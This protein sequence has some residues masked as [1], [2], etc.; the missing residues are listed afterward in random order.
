VQAGL[1]VATGRRQPDY[2]LF[3]SEDERRAADLRPAEARF[4]DAVA[5]ADAKRFARPL[6]RRRVRGSLSEDPVAQIINYVAITHRRWG[7]LT[8]GGVWRLYGAERN[9]LAGAHFEVDLVAALERGD[10]VALR[11]FLALF[12]AAAFRPDAD[13]RSFLDRAL[14][15]STQNARRVGAELERQVFGA[16]PRIAEGLLAEDERSPASLGV[17]FEHALILL[18]RLLFCLHAEARR[19][20]PVDNPHYREYSLQRQRLRITEEIGRGRVYS[21]R[22]DDLYNELRA[23]F[24]IV[25]KGDDALG[26]AEYDGGLFSPARHPWFEGRSVP[27]ELMAPA[28]DA[29]YRVGGELVDYGDL[30]VRHLGAI[31][32]RLLD[33]AL[34]DEDG[35]L[36][37]AAAPGRRESGSYFTPEP[38]VDR[39]VERVLEPILSERSRSAVAAGLRGR[40]ALDFLLDVRVL[41]PAMGSGH[42]LVA[43]AGWIAQHIA[44]DP[45]YDGELALDEI[46]RLVAERCIYGVDVNPMAVELAGLSLW[47]ATAR[48]GEPLTFLANL[49]VGNALVGARID[50]LLDAGDT[51]FGDRLARDTGE[52]LEQIEEI[53]RRGSA[54]GKDVHAKERLA[55]TAAALRDPLEKHADAHVRGNLAGEVGRLFHW[56]LEFP[57]VFLSVDGRP[58]DDAGFDAIVGN[59][60]YVRIQA[61][62]RDLAAYC[63]RRYASASGSFDAYVPFV[64]RALELLAPR[65][66]LGFIVPNKLL[67]VEYGQ[68]LRARLAAD[69]LVEEIVDFGDAQLFAGATNY[70]CILVLSKDAPEA[71]RYRRVRGGRAAVANALVDLDSVPAEP[72][73]SSELG[74]GPWVLATGGEARLLR[75][76]RRDAEPLAAVTSGIF[77]GLQT[78]ADAVYIVH[79]RGPLGAV[80]RVLS[81]ASGRELELE[82]DLLHPLASGVDVDRYACRPLQDLLLFPYV[83]DGGR[84]RLLTREELDRLPLTLR[85]LQEHER[86]LRSRERGTMDHAGWYGYVYPKSLGAHDRPKLGV[87]ATVRRLEVAAD[88][89]GSVY[90]HNVRVNG[91][92]LEDGG[93]SIW[94]LL[95][96]LNSMVLD[97]AFRRG[98]AVHA[99]GYYAA[100]K[101]FIAHL[102][103]RVPMPEEA[104]R[105]DELGRRLYHAARAIGRERHGFL[106]WLGD[107]LGRPVR[108]LPGRTALLAYEGRTSA[109]V[110]AVLARA[111]GDVAARARARGFRDELAR[112]HARSGRRL[113]ELRAAMEADELAAEVAVEELYELTAAQRQLVRSEY[114]ATGPGSGR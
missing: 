58:R 26:V 27:D 77:T 82:P 38:I 4:A 14:A 101:Q 113:H 8:N 50:E 1:A 107:V 45:A 30:S 99:N 29:L 86:T 83:R 32:E 31:Y 85:Y 74:A 23:L 48:R 9:L 67:K 63:R 71:L 91:I 62:S 100:N 2:A 65:G 78:N 34:E 96:L 70:T 44:T 19:L 11:L 39:I 61:L 88:P 52:L 105:L 93:P 54:T 13:G 111:R 5:V 64:E 40:D 104:A 102:P 6:D 42:F 57:E 10:D 16:V 17:A 15:E 60:P 92:L 22:S 110:L 51:I 59:P 90:F 87:A 114:Q 81:R 20:L 66:R 80:R 84:M 98:A 43:A 49:R 112:E 46:Q 53:A 89:D 7:V 35:R 103:I 68:R 75:E 97:W 33:Y 108:E 12:S 36:V 37:L 94:T 109:E 3:V 79:D 76:L 55:T 24:R 72:F 56:E 18:Y 69:R 106:Y 41:D 25:D 95:V 21:R 47:L 28:L 73:A